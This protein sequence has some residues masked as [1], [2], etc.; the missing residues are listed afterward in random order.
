MLHSLRPRRSIFGRGFAALFAV[1]LCFTLTLLK[2]LGGCASD[3]GEARTPE[4][5]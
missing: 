4:G 2:P 5:Y 3:G 1:R